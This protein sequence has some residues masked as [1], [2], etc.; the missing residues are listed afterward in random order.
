[1]AALKEVQCASPAKA[2]WQARQE[3]K[4]ALRSSQRAAW[5]GAVNGKTKADT[6]TIKHALL[7]H[8]PSTTS[9]G[10]NSCGGAETG[11]Q[12]EQSL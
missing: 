3:P 9:G 2:H 10:Y 11:A 5:A 8:A 4:H 6:A 1:V 12:V 7:G